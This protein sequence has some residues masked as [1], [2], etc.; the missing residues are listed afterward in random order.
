MSIWVEGPEGL[1]SSELASA[2]L[3]RGVAIE[4]GFVCYLDEP[5]P[6]NTFK[7]GFGA[8]ALEAIKPGIEILGELVISRA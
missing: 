4:P 8:V 6:A 7:V 2:A 1:D 3:Q 5:R